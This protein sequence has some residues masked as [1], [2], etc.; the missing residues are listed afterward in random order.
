LFPAAAALALTSS[1]LSK[2]RR[3][4]RPRARK[5][6]VFVVSSR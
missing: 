6:I 3:P 4:K 1:S 2:H 5:N